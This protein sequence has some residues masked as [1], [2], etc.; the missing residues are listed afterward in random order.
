[1]TTTKAAAKET[2][3][4]RSSEK[5]IEILIAIFIVIGTAYVIFLA[6]KAGKKRFR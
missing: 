2:K 1:M 5:Y 3:A 6:V 4:E